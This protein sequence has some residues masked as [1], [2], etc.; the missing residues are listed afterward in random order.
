M[1]LKIIDRDQIK[2]NFIVGGFDVNICN[3][4]LHKISRVIKFWG[5]HEI[6]APPAPIPGN[7][8]TPWPQSPDN[9]GP[10]HVPGTS[11]SV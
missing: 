1:L 10:H 7:M 8:G 2:N 4:G 3:N 9:M 6:G 11:L 5:P